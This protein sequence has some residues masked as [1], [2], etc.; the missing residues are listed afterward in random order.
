MKRLLGLLVMSA[1][2]LW[3]TSADSEDGAPP[4]AVPEPAT[5]GLMGAGIAA[6]GFATWRKNRK[7]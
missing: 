6:I 7:K 4:S 5:I 1:A 2:M 3:G